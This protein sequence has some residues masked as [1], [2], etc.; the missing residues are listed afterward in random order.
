MNYI[1]KKNNEDTTIL[2]ETN[3][4]NIYFQNQINAS[5]RKINY[6]LYL[7]I[8][9]IIIDHIIILLRLSF[10]KKPNIKID[11]KPTLKNLVYNNT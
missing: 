11:K 8:I 3:T 2:N 5:L 6:K 4:Q 10:K 7:I 1:K 9:F